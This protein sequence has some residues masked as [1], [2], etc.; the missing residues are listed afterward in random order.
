MFRYYYTSIRMAKM[1][2]T[3]PN[4]DKDE[5]KLDHSYI[6][7]GNVTWF[8][9]FYKMKHKLPYNPQIILWVINPEK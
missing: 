7:C 4:A 6:A 1:N 2:V 8:S 5:E 9:F 3:K